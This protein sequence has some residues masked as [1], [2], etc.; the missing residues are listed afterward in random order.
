MIMVANRHV[1]IF[2][3]IKMS[4]SRLKV[5][6]SDAMVLHVALAHLGD[7]MNHYALHIEHGLPKSMHSQWNSYPLSNLYLTNNFFR[8]YRL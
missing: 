2:Q 8:T 5:R 6:P 7:E 3:C 1:F 4:T